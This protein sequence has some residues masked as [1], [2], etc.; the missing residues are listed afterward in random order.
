MATLVPIT[1]EFLRNYYSTAAVL[2]I[3]RVPEFVEQFSAEQE[4]TM[5]AVT[6]GGPI[7]FTAVAER[8]KPHRIEETLFRCREQ[9][10]YALLLTSGQTVKK[11]AVRASVRRN[12]PF[13]VRSLR[14]QAALDGQGV[15]PEKLIGWQQKVLPTCQR[16]WGLGP[17]LCTLQV[18]ELNASLTET[19]DSIGE[20]QDQ[21]TA[22]VP[23]ST[24]RLGCRSRCHRVER[25]ALPRAFYNHR[26]SDARRAAHPP[27]ARLSLRLTG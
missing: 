27:F 10:E 25:S 22:R 4:R 12:A 26:R 16:G 3:G 20:F 5:Q 6:P 13:S 14:V 21:N 15:A 7:K 2:D 8:P 17:W 9:L 11:V 19:F 1:R 24:V 18:G 23:A